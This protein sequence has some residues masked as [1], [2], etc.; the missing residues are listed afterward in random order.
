MARSSIGLGCQPLTLARRVR[1][2]HGLLNGQVAQ[3]EDARR[4]ERRA[5]KGLGV[6]I[7]PWSLKH[8]RRGRCPTGFPYRPVRP[9]RYR[10]LQLAGG[11]GPT[12]PGTDRRLV[13]LDRRVRLPDPPLMTGYANWHSGEVESLVPVGSSPTSVTDKEH[14]PV[15]QRRR[16]LGDNQESAGSIPAGI[17]DAKWSVGVLAAHLRGKEEDPVQLRDGPL[18]DTGR[19]SKGKTLGLHPGD[20]RVRF[21]GGPLNDTG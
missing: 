9:V 12:G 6:Q 16:R 18:D 10:G 1:F 13:S 15:V 5:R 2:P 21:P 11:P 20:A 19:W 7:S 4:S 17:T 14:D 8:C 3:L